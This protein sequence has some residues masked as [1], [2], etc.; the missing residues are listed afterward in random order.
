MK[1]DPPGNICGEAPFVGDD[2]GGAAPWVTIGEMLRKDL[3]P[4]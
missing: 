1:D 3:K 2:G 4:T